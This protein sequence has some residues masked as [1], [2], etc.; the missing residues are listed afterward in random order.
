[1]VGVQEGIQSNVYYIIT[2]ARRNHTE[3]GKLMYKNK[4]QIE[5]N[6]GFMREPRRF[7]MIPEEQY[8]CDSGNLQL[9]A[10]V[11]CVTRSTTHRPRRLP[12]VLR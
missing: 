7:L 5:T 4:D 9:L 2:G 1:M 8:R 12:H 3:L 11:S 6:Q 10:D